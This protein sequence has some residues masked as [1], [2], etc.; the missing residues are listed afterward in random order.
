MDLAVIFESKTLYLELR[1]E[2]ETHGLEVCVL[3]R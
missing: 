1:T 2:D 3:W